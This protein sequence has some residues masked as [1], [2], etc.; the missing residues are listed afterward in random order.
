MPRLQSTSTTNSLQERRDQL[1]CKVPDWRENISRSIAIPPVETGL[2]RI[3]RRAVTIIGS[4]DKLDPTK[5]ENNGQK[6]NSDTDQ[7]Y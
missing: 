6:D 4:I 2:A 7:D 5:A 3:D 1:L